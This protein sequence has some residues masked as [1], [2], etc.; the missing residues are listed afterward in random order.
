MPLGPQI[1]IRRVIMHLGPRI[2]I[3]R[4]VMHLGPRIG[5]LDPNNHIAYIYPLRT[6]YL[7]AFR[8]YFSISDP[9]YAHRIRLHRA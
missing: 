9:I 2:I 5:V 6:Y 7:I 1:L 8:A 3:S 4:V